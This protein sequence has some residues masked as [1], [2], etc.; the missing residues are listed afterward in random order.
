MSLSPE[1]AHSMIDKALPTRFGTYDFII[2]IR[3][4]E[5]PTGLS[6]D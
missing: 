3:V 2:I 6:T 5:P 1:N 4:E